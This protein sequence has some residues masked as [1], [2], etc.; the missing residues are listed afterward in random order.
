MPADR[1]VASVLWRRLNDE[2]SDVCH[3]FEQSSGWL[4][5]GTAVFLEDNRI[6]ELHYEV[7]CDARWITQTGFVSG[8]VGE[9]RFDLEVSVDEER[10]WQVNGKAVPEASGCV[11]L[12]LNFT[13]ATNLIQFRRLGL[14]IGTYAEV[15]TAWFAVPEFTLEVLPQTMTRIDLQSYD[16]AA[17]TIGYAGLIRTNELG[18]VLDYPE[19]WSARCVQTFS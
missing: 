2:G 12:D 4:V 18:I 16:Y 1:K 7:N 15:P 6:A 3:L 11:D 10:N 5:A 19:L 8:S 14:G 13:P 9:R 17:P